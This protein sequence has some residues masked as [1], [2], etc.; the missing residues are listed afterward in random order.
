[1]PTPASTS[2][3]I[4][5][6]PSFETSSSSSSALSQSRPLPEDLVGRLSAISV[7]SEVKL[8]ALR[9]IKNQIIGN[10]TKKLSFLKLGAI[11]R[12]VS[13]LSSATCGDRGGCGGSDLDSI[14]IQSAA[15]IGSFACGFDAGVE[16]VLEAGALPILLTLISHPSEKVMF[17]LF[18]FPF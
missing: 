5:Q 8:K 18:L 13:I 9:D 4:P 6:P 2:A 15:V 14:I 12:V 10:R 11:P 1:M 3:P 7:S 17:T 16:A